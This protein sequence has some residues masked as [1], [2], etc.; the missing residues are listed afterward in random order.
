MTTSFEGGGF[1]IQ[2]VSP[3]FIDKLMTLDGRPR[4]LADVQIDQKRVVRWP[5]LREPLQSYRWIRRHGWIRSYTVIEKVT[6]K[7]ATLVVEEVE[8]IQ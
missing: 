4:L 3:D 8:R 2:A 5:G 1:K 6:L 7:G